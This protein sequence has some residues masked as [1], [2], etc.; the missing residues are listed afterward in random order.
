MKI[1]V[2]LFAILREKAGVG[3]LELTLDDRATVQ[4]AVDA[5][6]LRFPSISP[7]LPSVRYAVDR[8]YSNLEAPL[9]EGS[10]LALIPP[11]S[12]G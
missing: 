10:E 6:L 1:Q 3:Q 11:V 12:G 5:L 9:A 8:E 4:M 2:H 7:Y